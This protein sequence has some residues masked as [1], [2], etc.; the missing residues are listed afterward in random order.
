MNN[1]QIQQ[2]ET[3]ITV[4]SVSPNAFKKG[5]DQAQIRQTVMT[6]YPSTRVTNSLTSG[7]FN[8]GDFKLPAGKSFESTRITWIP[9]P[10]G[11]TLAQVEKELSKNPKAR[12]ARVISN[13]LED[14]LTEEQK[15]A[16]ATGLTTLST[17]EEKH[18]VKDASGIAVSPR[19]YRQNFFSKTGAP[20]ID[21]R[22]A[23]KQSDANAERF[24]TREEL[25][26]N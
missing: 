2:T 1:S 19:Q 18:L 15:N 21:K 10:Q 22:T 13:N 8:S 14:V 5:V 11:T 6:I 16:V 25:T 12:I 23:G 4:D 17:L 7:L 24:V 9:V 26:R 20:D 3:P